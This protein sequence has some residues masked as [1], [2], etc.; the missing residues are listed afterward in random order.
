MKTHYQLIRWLVLSLIIATA[1]LAHATKPIVEESLVFA[2][3]DGLIAVEAEHFFKQT[4]T[5]I[6]EWHLTHSNMT[7]AITPDGD[8]NHVAGASGGAY[9]GILPDTRRT[10]ADKLIRG[11]NFSPEAGKMALLHYKVQI[12][13]P[14][15]YTFGFVP[16]RQVPKTTASMLALMELG[17]PAANVCNGATASKVGF[18]KASSGPKNSTAV[19]L[20]RYFLISTSPANTRFTS[21]CEKTVSNL[22]NG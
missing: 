3:N 21:R 1:Q 8:P 9:L 7:P 6:R 10:H 19:K 22:T 2:E 16:T 12:N 17:P 4:A 15:R 14:G 18:G 20:T 5:D 13:K 11:T